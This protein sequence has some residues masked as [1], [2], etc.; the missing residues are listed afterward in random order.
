MIEGVD[1]YEEKAEEHLSDTMGLMI[2]SLGQIKRPNSPIKNVV[3]DLSN[4]G[5]GTAPSAAGT[6]Y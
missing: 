3:L 5:G 6:D 1:Y 4:N 2:Y